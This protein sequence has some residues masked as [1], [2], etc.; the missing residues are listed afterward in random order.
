MRRTIN[1][2]FNKNQIK[3]RRMLMRSRVR[4]KCNSH[5][6]FHLIIQ[7]SNVFLEPM[8]YMYDGILYKINVLRDQ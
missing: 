5:M 8:F 7:L 4:Y 3:K 6:C 2:Y 1:F